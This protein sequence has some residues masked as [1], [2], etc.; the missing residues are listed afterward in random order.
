MRTTIRSAERG[1]ME[2]QRWFG[3]EKGKERRGFS[4]D[5]EDEEEERFRIDTSMSL[6]TGKAKELFL[7]EEEEDDLDEEKYKE[8]KRIKLKE[9]Q[10]YDYE[11]WSC[12]SC[13]FINERQRLSCQ[14][15]GRPKGKKIEPTSPLSTKRCSLHCSSLGR[16]AE[17]D[18]EELR[19]VEQEGQRISCDIFSTLADELL[20]IVFSHLDLSMCFPLLSQ[21]FF[22][23]LLPLKDS[24]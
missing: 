11:R 24:V 6:G 19:S 18:L 17:E 12:E 7:S 10:E 8:A 13:T 5:E 20:L 3:E 14:V 9:S 4:S 21:T 23:L 2:G 15:C 22:P 16:R 1:S